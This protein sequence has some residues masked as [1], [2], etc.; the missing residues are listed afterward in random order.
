MMEATKPLV[1]S[2]HT[3]QMSVNA[4]NTV[5]PAHCRAIKMVVMRGFR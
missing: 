3:Y 1:T 2:H 4:M 5:A